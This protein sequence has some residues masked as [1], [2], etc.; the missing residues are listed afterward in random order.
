MS[1]Y[2]ILRSAGRWSDVF[3]LAPPGVG[4]GVGEAVLGRSS[5]NQIVLQSER[6]SRRHARIFWN[7]GDRDGEG[8]GWMIEDLGSRNGT[9]VNGKPIDSPVLLSDPSA[10]ELAGFSITFSHRID[11]GGPVRDVK[12]GLGDASATSDD[13]T[14]EF[15]A[16]AITDRRA[17]SRYLNFAGADGQTQGSP[18]SGRLLS[19]AFALARAADFDQVIERTL[20]AIDDHRQI[21][22]AGIY[23]IREI[24]KPKPQNASLHESNFDGELPLVGTRQ[25]GARSYRRAPNR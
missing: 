8:S 13:L 25:H 7:S 12:Q 24:D 18:V 16:S 1:A 2:L 22:T 10:I 11:V 17:E 14:S 6:A 19:L 20:D 15:D 5:S 9:V 21:D 4:A 3:R 23:A